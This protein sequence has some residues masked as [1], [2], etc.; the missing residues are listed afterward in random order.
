MGARHFIRLGASVSIR[1][2]PVALA[3]QVYLRLFKLGY[4]LGKKSAYGKQILEQW[5]GTV[6]HQAALGGND[7][8]CALLLDAKVDASIQ[9]VFG[10]T[11]QETATHFG[12][13]H[14]M[15]FV[16]QRRENCA[17]FG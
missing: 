4:M 10:R 6:L 7:A 1:I 16:E 2:R 9:N 3:A 5:H 15:A 12:Y 17:L 14:M 11:P 13:E 8:V